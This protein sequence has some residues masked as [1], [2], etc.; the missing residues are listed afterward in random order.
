MS[1]P[2][3]LLEE[4]VRAEAAR[5]ARRT[6]LVGGAVAAAARGAGGATPKGASLPLAEWGDPGPL[7]RRTTEADGDAESQPDTRLART[8]IDADGLASTRAGPFGPAALPY[9]RPRV[10]WARG[11]PELAIMNPMLPVTALTVHPDGLD[12]LVTTT[13]PRDMA[14][15]IERYRVGHRARGWGDIGYHLV[16]DRGGAVWQGRSVCWQGAHVKD[17]NEGNIGVLVMG[18]FEV[19]QPTAAQLDTLS[20]V[21]ADLRRIYRIPNGRVLTHREWAGAQTLCPGRSLQPGVEKIR[22]EGRRA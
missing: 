12:D 11:A 4:A 14:A 6:F 19:Q 15:R 22:R 17:H 10:L 18:N 9:A 13:A 20:R 16:I 2:E 5:L 8:E 21:I 3:A 7:A 1:P